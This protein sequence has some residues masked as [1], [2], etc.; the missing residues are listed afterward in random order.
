VPL[1][2]QAAAYLEQ[3]RSL[4]VPEPGEV[5][6]DQARAPYNDSA[7]ALFGPVD[8]V[9]EVEDTVADGVPVRIYR[10][11]AAQAG[12]LV[13]FH[14]GGWV[15]GGIASHDP[16]C[17]ALAARSG[18][19]VI[20]VDYRL[21]PEHPHPAPI[22]DAWTATRWA[23]ERFSP[24]AVAGD[25]AGGQLAASVT[26]RARAADLPIALQVLIYPATDHGSERPSYRENAEVGP[27]SP[28]LMDWFW[29]AYVPDESRT[30][31][32]D[33]SPIR[34][35]SLAELPPALVITA[36]FDPLRDAGEAYARRLQEA[37]VPVTL[38][39]YDGMIHGFFRLAAVIERAHTGIDEVA[40]AVRATLLAAD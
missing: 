16:V 12:G 8:E 25:S 32:P 14:G 19:A 29:A 10:P 35:E 2:P 38:S 9:A 37:G 40:A 1:D 23:A 33:C 7:A 36:E 27:L 20:A 39:R 11:A 26:L 3:I 34:A 28:G 31:E 22:E 6:P 4:G 17:R 5:T 15:L 18:C 30:D 21:A 24:L 13:Y